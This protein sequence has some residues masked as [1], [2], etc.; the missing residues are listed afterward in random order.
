VFTGDN[1]TARFGADRSLI[2]GRMINGLKGPML[3]GG[4]NEPILQ[5]MKNGASPWSI[6]GSS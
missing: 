5:S 4:Y 1:G 6:L 3:E 2:N